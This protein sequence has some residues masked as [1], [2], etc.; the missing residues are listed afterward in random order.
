MLFWNLLKNYVKVEFFI[1]SLI[2]LKVEFWIYGIYWGVNYVCYCEVR[3]LMRIVVSS[4]LDVVVK[5]V[6]SYSLCGLVDLRMFLFLVLGIWWIMVV[7][8]WFR[9]V[10]GCVKCKLVW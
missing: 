6:W 7:V 10:I 3:R 8:I 1:F 4:K 2:E 5:V 9:E